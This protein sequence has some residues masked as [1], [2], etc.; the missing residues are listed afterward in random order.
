[1]IVGSYKERAFFRPTLEPDWSAQT[2]SRSK[3]WA[4]HMLAR[5]WLTIHP[6]GK[7]SK[8]VVSLGPRAHKKFVEHGEREE[9]SNDR[10]IT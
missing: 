6:R 5:D 2:L 4:Q 3:S 8:I 9:S 10:L 7:S 1:M